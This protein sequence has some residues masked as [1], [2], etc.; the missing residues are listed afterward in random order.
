MTGGLD[1]EELAVER[2][3]LL[4]SLE[5]LEREHAAGDL[6]D[7]DF[8][9][10][11]DDYT[12]RAA[13][14]L[15]ALD[16]GG[17]TVA[18]EPERARRRSVVVGALVVLFA[19]VAGVLVAQSVGR[20]DPGD[21][22]TGGIRQ[23]TTEQLN[24]ARNAMAGDPARAAELY[25]E[26]LERD[27]DNVEALTYQGWALRLAGRPQ[28]VTSLIRAATLDPTYPDVHAF[29][30]IVLFRDLGRAESA[31]KELQLLDALNPP[32]V[33]LELLEPIRAE[34]EAALASGSSSTTAPSSST[35]G[36][37]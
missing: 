4:S 34:I 17:A 19:V 30:A 31:A 11:R 35:T 36:A 20:R 7:A 23:S 18:P 25:E 32:A 28:G 22:A 3:F 13:A 33:L 37:R 6:D 1:P 2:D 24:Q 29:L 26:I 12:A 8:E 16:A 15:R 5:D 27:P 14:V 10:L 21:V 9:A